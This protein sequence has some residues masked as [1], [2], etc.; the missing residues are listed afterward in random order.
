MLADPHT[1]PERRAFVPLRRCD[2][3]GG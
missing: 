3:P 1:T 2:H